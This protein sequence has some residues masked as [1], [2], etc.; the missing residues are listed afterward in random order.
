MAKRVFLMVLVL[1]LGFAGGFIGAKLS[2]P[3]DDINLLRED[4][5]ALT[6][7]VAGVKKALASLEDLPD[8]IASLE[9]TVATL[10]KEVTRLK[11]EREVTAAAP[12]RLLR[13][14]SGLPMWTLRPCSRRSSPPG[15]P[16]RK[17][18]PPSSTISG[19]PMTRGRWTRR[20]T[21][22]SS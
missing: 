11:E 6:D 2:Y 1:G 15:P 16:P 13:R 21:P 10:G 3:E 14:P 4:L 5:D 18:T 7:H 19:R 22:R 20:P 8:R 17:P 12:N 9:E